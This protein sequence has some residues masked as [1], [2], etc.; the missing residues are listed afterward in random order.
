MYFVYMVRCRDGSHYTGLA[1]YICRRMREHYGQTAACARYTRAHPV[2]A[3]DALWQTG[4]RA[5]A[6][7]LEA[8]I[9]RLDKKQKLALVREPQLL[10]TLCG[11]KLPTQNYKAV[12]GVTLESCLSGE[13]EAHFFM[14]L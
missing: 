4:T 6:A 10:L 5:E 11:E 2:V 8:V 3:L 9:K 12:L 13:A 1:K 7:S 14:D